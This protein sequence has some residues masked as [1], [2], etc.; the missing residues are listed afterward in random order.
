MIVT[1]KTDF[2]EL[3]QDVVEFLDNYVDVVDGD[4]EPR[5]NR[6]M[7]LTT[8]CEE[9]LRELEGLDKPA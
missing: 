5:P 1:P 6:A 9:A 4:G 8:R 3:L 2:L 7:N